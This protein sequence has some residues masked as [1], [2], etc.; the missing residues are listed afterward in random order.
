MTA[1]SAV[2]AELMVA[3]QLKGIVQIAPKVR[4]IPDQELAGLWQG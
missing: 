3:D 2:V 4:K 1:V